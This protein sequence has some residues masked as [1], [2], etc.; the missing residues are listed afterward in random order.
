M[1]TTWE[2]MCVGQRDMIDFVTM[3]HN[4]HIV[5]GRQTDNMAL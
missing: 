3:G 2:Y 5:P 1:N 4:R